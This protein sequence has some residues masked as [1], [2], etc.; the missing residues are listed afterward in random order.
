MTN[1]QILW[2][3]RVRVGLQRA[4]IPV[5]LV[6]VTRDR[7]YLEAVLARAS[8]LTDETAVESALKLMSQLGIIN[9]SRAMNPK[10]DGSILRPRDGGVAPDSA[11]QNALRGGMPPAAAGSSSQSDPAPVEPGRFSTPIGATTGTSPTLAP[12]GKNYK[13]GLR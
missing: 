6:R 8:E 12:G 5:D 11:A 4:Q 9:G 1:E 13:R 10:R 2:L 7:P 3:A